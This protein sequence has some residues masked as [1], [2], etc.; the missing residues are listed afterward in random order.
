M[1][2]LCELSDYSDIIRIWR[3]AFGDSEEYILT[4]LDKFKEYVYVMDKDA[5]MTL[6]PVSLNDKKGH[7]LYAVAVDKEKRAAGRSV[8]MQ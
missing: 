3:E 5:I 7:Y 8:C 6:F 1:I 4:F 2:R